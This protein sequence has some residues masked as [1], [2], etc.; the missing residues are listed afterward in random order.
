MLEKE[1]ETWIVE[2]EE[3]VKKDKKVNDGAEEEAQ[4]VPWSSTKCITI[5]N[6][7]LS[8]LLLFVMV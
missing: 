7:I 1:E 8:L 6:N 4:R 3:D 2:E 5:G